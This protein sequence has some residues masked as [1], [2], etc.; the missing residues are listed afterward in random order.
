MNETRKYL[1]QANRVLNE[2]EKRREMAERLYSIAIR[3]API[4][5]DTPKGDFEPGKMGDCIAEKADLEKEIDELR[6]IWKTKAI[7]LMRLFYCVAKGRVLEVL[8]LH[9]IHNMTIGEISDKI[10]VADHHVREYRNRGERLCIKQLEL[11]K[12]LFG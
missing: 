12:E 11:E 3:I 6:K 8:M 9:Y 4:L 5:S 7:E 2:I 1:N 10:S